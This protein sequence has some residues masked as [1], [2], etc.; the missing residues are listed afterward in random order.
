MLKLVPGYL[1]FQPEALVNVKWGFPRLSVDCEVIISSVFFQ[2]S[3]TNSAT[4]HAPGWSWCGYFW[5]FIMHLFF[6]FL[7]G[8][9]MSVGHMIYRDHVLFRGWNI[10]CRAWS[11]LRCVAN[12]NA[13]IFTTVAA[14]GNRQKIIP[15]KLGRRS[16]GAG[17]FF[18]TLLT[19]FHV[20]ATGIWCF[21]GVTWRVYGSPAQ[22]G[23]NRRLIESRHSQEWNARVNVVSR[24][25]Q[26]NSAT[27][28]LSH[29]YRMCKIEEWRQRS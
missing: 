11:S 4:Q 14:R 16:E 13:V 27:P 18:G 26:I 19:P 22:W 3:H 6:L 29:V 20:F 28:F 7:R 21:V 17:P 10:S 1:C 23:Q 25:W 15:N 24:I 9:W 5:D 8:G 12:I 2:F